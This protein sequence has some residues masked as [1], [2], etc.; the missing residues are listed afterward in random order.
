M[1]IHET[2]LPKEALENLQIRQGSVVVDATLG[3]GGHALAILKIV[4]PEGKLIAFDQD[5]KAVEAFEE[6]IAGLKPKPKKK[7]IAIVRANFSSL[8]EN[9]VALKIAEVDAVLADL[10][11]SSD[12]LEN[13]GRGFSFRKD[14]WLDMRMD[15]SVKL[16]AETIVN[17]YPEAELARLIK[18]FGDERYAGSIARAIVK[19]RR[20]GRI[21]TTAQLVGI[22]GSAVPAKYRHNRINFA[23]KTFQ[24]LRMET[25]S[26]IKHLESFLSQALGMLRKGGRMGIISFHSGEDRVVKNFLRQNARGCICPPE[27]PICRC[28]LTPGLR[29]ITKKPIVPGAAEVAANARARSAKLRVAEKI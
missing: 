1:T 12:Q 26:E 15:G 13:S 21:G 6:R 20:L 7:S 23:T 5:A 24:A 19:Q 18:E 2:V 11:L 4:G 28:G 27:F 3:G 8:A 9:L 16:T 25:N 14:E 10:G 29:I 22:I 17:G